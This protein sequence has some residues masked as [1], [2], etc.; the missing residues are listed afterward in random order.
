MEQ[1][2]NCKDTTSLPDSRLL[3]LHVS[4]WVLDVCQLQREL[5]PCLPVSGFL[6]SKGDT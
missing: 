1:L 4:P 5:H 3:I 2:T 6:Y